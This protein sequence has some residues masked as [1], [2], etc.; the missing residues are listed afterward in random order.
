VPRGKHLLQA[1]TW[2]S[3]RSHHEEK[4]PLA[5]RK[6]KHTMLSKQR[7]LERTSVRREQ[8]SEDKCVLFNPC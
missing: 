8:C 2:E 7:G 5:L 3:M 1:P 6:A 4:L